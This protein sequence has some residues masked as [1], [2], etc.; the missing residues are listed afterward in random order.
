MR[1]DKSLW[2]VEYI[3]PESVIFDSTKQLIIKAKELLK[4]NPQ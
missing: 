3:P 4:W 2:G 1:N